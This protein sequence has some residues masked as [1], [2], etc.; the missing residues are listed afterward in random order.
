ME[1]NQLKHLISEWFSNRRKTHPEIMQPG[2]LSPLLPLEGAR[3]DRLCQYPKYPNSLNLEL[4]NSLLQN[5]VK[6]AVYEVQSHG[7][8]FHA[9]V[10]IALY[11][12]NDIL[13]LDDLSDDSLFQIFLDRENIPLQPAEKMAADLLETKFHFLTLGFRGQV[14][15]QKAD[16]PLE[17]VFDDEPEDEEAKAKLE[18]I[19]AKLHPPRLTQLATYQQLDFFVWTLVAGSIYYLSCKFDAAGKFTW[20]GERLSNWVGKS[21][22]PR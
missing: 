15:G 3:I 20:T 2:K 12:D 17:R 6:A 22:A 11:G 9:E 13:W 10:I 1:E 19:G 7:P 14:I 16:I 5:N 4:H 18:E 8:G 21:Y